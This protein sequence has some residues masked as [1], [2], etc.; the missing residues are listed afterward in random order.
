MS[1]D[2][3]IG[4]DVG[5]TNT[6]AVVLDPNDKIL[7]WT[8]APTTTDVSSGIH[9]AI[10]AVLSDIGDR[11]RH[12][13]RVMLGTTHA[14][15]AILERRG[16]GRV[17]A[18]RIGAPATTAIPPLTGWP[19]DLRSVACPAATVVHG[20]YLV[21]GHPLAP[22]D[23]A[24]VAAFLESV[25]GKVDAVAVTGMFSPAFR[26]QE[27]ETA[28]IA[29]K[30]LGADIP[31]TMSHELGSLGLIERENAAVLNASLYAVA[32]DV[33]QSLARALAEHG[34]D[35]TCYFAQNDG[36]LMA[37][38]HAE[39]YPVLT[40][41]S[42]PANSI[43]GAAYLSG[44]DE[45]IVVDVGGTSSDFGVLKQGF[46]RESAL[47]ADIGGVTTNF[48][49]PDVLAVAIGG[50]TMISGAAQAPVVGPQSVGYRIRERGL[51]FGGDTATLTDAAVAAGRTEIAGRALPS[52]V[53]SELFAAALRASDR[54][55]AEAVDSVSLGRHDNRL[56]AVGGGA[57]LVP[58]DLEGAAQVV[59]PDHGQ[60][61]NAVGAA[62][63]LASG[64]WETIIPTGDGRRE[65]IEE[66]SDVARRR[67]V[68]AGAAPDQVEVVE[69]TEV[70][71][72]YLP[73]PSV[74]LSVKAAGP[75][76]RS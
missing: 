75:L 39:R 17:A 45:A 7:A 43:R 54:R 11:A 62:I 61:A 48:R 68:H 70:P 74:R 67:A 47:A 2:L 20:G 49:M 27:L 1:D 15:N 55:L 65:A 53:D 29:A 8:K 23:K 63:A 35:V 32:S 3:R 5:G 21:D 18:I 42:G 73:K 13:R 14:T 76:A 66:A 72:S 37:V 12:V 52:H 31:V 19:A 60:V 36:T 16:L 64:W 10:A 69:I 4:I 38:D 51:V 58:D 40:I 9:A 71:L 25:G 26:D 46:P 56:V 59:R 28:E 41:G 6:D 33:T 24:A 22:F 50:G 57:F 44:L 30:V 34:L